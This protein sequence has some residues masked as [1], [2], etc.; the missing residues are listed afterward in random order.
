MGRAISFIV[1]RLILIGAALAAAQGPIAAKPKRRQQPRLRRRGPGWRFSAE[2]VRLQCSRFAPAARERAARE[3]ANGSGI[4]FGG[5]DG[6]WFDGAPGAD[7][8]VIHG[9]PGHDFAAVQVGAERLRPGGCGSPLPAAVRIKMERAFAADFSDVR[10]HVGDNP[11]LIDADAFTR[12]R[13]INVAPEAYRPRTS[14]GE[15]LLGHE[16][17]HVVQQRA[18]RVAARG[19]QVPTNA[20]PGLESEADAMAAKAV[21]GD[22]A[23]GGERTPAGA[24]ATTDGAAPIQAKGKSKSWKRRRARELERQRNLRD[25]AV[26]NEAAERAR[27]GA[28]RQAKGEGALPAIDPPDSRGS[29]TLAH[30]STPY[31]DK[32]MNRRRSLAR[33]AGVRFYEPTPP[34]PVEENAPPRRQISPEQAQ[35]YKKIRGDV[36]DTEKGL[37]D[38]HYAFY[39]AQDP[40]MRIA[41]DVYKRVYQ[42]HF[43]KQLPEDSHFMRFPGPEDE[44]FNQH[45]DVQLHEGLPRQVRF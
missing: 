31:V 26:R 32:N 22:R 29:A 19:G 3:R 20:D 30:L 24:S 7:P 11:A 4:R 13:H 33:G 21:A 2:R 35:Q 45:P 27:F 44:E 23:T 16:L 15:R 34:A 43:G 9:R 10:L 18:G 41:Q 40:R 42:R 14:A 39:H 5:S 38:S 12:G 25:Q 28:L 37:A 8:Q 6:D 17:A 36:I 1:T